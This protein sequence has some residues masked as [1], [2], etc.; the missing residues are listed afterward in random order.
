MEQDLISYKEIETDLYH[1]K[2]QYKTQNL[3]DNSM[4]NIWLEKAKHYVGEY[5]KESQSEY[6]I[7]LISFCNNYCSHSIFKINH[8]SFIECINCHEQHCIGC[9][10]QPLSGRDFSTCLIGFL[11]ANYIR[12]LNEGTDIVIH[13]TVIYTVHIIFC[14]LFT[15][16]YIGFIFHMIGFLSHQKRNRLENNGEI[17]DFIDNKNKLYLIYIYSILKGILFF[18]YI[19]TFLPLMIIL[20]LSSIFSK[21]YYFRIWTFYVTII[22][23]GGMEIKEKY[24]LWLII[25]WISNT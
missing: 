7:L 17:H 19:I 16:L 10:R 2:L 9:G 3:R 15:S 6:D 18:P 25:A 21:I 4:Y 1:F 11:K 22:T 24:F 23:A 14:L 8:F 5:N 12:A 20:L 13:N